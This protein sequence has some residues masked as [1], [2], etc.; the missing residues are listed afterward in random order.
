MRT[1]FRRYLALGSIGL[2][3]DDLH[4][5]GVTPKARIGKD[6]GSVQPTRFALGPLAYILKNRVY[7]GE[8]VYRGEVFPGEQQ[9]IVDRE[10]FEAVQARLKAGAVVRTARRSESPAFLMGVL[11]DDRGNRMSPSRANK[12]SVRYRY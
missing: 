1:I 11:H 8:V 7:I 5:R 9:P 2:L 6:G 12:N 10:L 4:R 3:I